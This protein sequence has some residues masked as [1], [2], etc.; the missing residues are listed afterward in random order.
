M[1]VEV[2]AAEEGAALGAALLA[3]V[4]VGVWRCVAQACEIA[5]RVSAVVQP[6]PERSA[7]MGRSYAAYRKLYPALRQI[8]AENQV[9]GEG[10]MQSQSIPAAVKAR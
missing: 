7:L 1:P 4:G 2:L 9:F 10:I 5:V 3:G 6:D 8:G